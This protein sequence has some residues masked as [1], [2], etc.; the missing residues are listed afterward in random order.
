MPRAGLGERPLQINCDPLVW[1]SDVFMLHG[2]ATTP[3]SRLA[4]PTRETRAAHH[5]H[6]PVH[7]R[8]G[9]TSTQQLEHALATQMAYAKHVHASPDA[10][11]PGA[12]HER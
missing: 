9:K 8:L 2:G 11:L 5:F 7:P 4:L 1:K 10:F 12:W 6:I 3:R